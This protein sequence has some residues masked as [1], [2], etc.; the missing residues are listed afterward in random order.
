MVKGGA[1]W[2][3]GEIHLV[4]T[5]GCRSCRCGIWQKAA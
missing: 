4:P 1:K 2:F 5:Q 3:K